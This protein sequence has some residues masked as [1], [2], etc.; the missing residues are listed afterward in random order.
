MQKYALDVLPGDQLMIADR[1]AIVDF[2]TDKRDRK[3]IAGYFDDDGAEFS[4]VVD[5]DYVVRVC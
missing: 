4:L 2:V 1:T 3:L 5:H